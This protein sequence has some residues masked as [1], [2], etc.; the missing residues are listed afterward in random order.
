MRFLL[1]QVVSIQLYRKLCKQSSGNSW[2]CGGKQLLYGEK[3]GDTGLFDGVFRPKLAKL[4]DFSVKLQKCKKKR[5]KQGGG[6]RAI[7]KP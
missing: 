2:R 1:K 7:M 4:T 6:E 5:E 3:W